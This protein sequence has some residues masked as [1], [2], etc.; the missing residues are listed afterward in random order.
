MSPYIYGCGVL[1]LASQMQTRIVVQMVV[2]E[3]W[4]IL[5]HGMLL[6]SIGDFLR[7]KYITIS[8]HLLLRDK[9]NLLNKGAQRAGIKIIWIEMLSGKRV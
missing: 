8:H 1:L 4:Y 2:V 6:A 9:K 5:R 7:G 3:V